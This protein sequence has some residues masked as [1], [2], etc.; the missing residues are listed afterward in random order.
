[1]TPVDQI[2]DAILYEGYV[3][4]PYRRSAIKNRQRFTIG[5]VYPRG[6]SE[7]FGPA[8]PW[9]T[10]TEVLV[11]GTDPRVTVR[12]RF[13]QVVSRQIVR[14]DR[15]G[16]S[17]NVDALEVDGR[18]YLSWDEATP[19]EFTTPAIR[20]ADLASEPFR[21]SI[22]ENEGSA[23]ERVTD[24]GGVLRG[25]IVRRWDSLSGNL[26]ASASLVGRGAYRL[27]VRLEN[28]AWWNGECREET[29]KRTFAGAHKILTVSGGQFV[30]LTDPPAELARAAETCRNFKTWPA[31]A[32]E[33]GERTT[34]LSSPIILADYPQVAPESGG[35]F[36]DGAEID[37][38]LLLNV[39]ALSDEE[40]AEMRAADPKAA[41]ILA[42]SEAL[43]GEDFLSLH[44]ALRD[45]RVLRPDAPSVGSDGF[46]A[47]SSAERSAVRSVTVDGVELCSGSRVRLRPRPGRDVMDFALA[48]KAATVESVEEDYEGRVHLTVALDGD[49][50]LDMGKARFLGHRF[51]FDPSEVIPLTEREGNCD[52]S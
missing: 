46:Q 30:P 49:P 24:S 43:T 42:R 21:L 50:A 13:L 44:G 29:L 10:Q 45:F 9:Y 36:C 41:A 22:V 51:F 38:L 52:E 4:W 20:V 25:A 12:V 6:H 48:N 15:D 3:L 18:R 26:T 32:G 33:T 47:F 39:L 37:Q 34:M 40:K 16:T 1:M 27:S 23:E 2:A 8:D 28:T 5:G 17:D 35:D 11:T 31:L 19:R 7:R 14:T